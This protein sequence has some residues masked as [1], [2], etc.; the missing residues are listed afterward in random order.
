MQKT[1]GRE[2]RCLLSALV[3]LALLPLAQV[4]C[5]EIDPDFELRPMDEVFY[6]DGSHEVGV[7]S[8]LTGGTWIK[9]PRTQAGHELKMDNVTKI[10][11]RRTVDTSLDAF[12]KEY[13][14][15][16]NA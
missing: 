1:D 7:I 6:K 12:S 2:T 15:S 13:A 10:L 8:E 11:K 14:A 16:K 4:L 9:N 3:L 5:G